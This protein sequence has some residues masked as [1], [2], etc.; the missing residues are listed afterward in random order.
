MQPG[1]GGFSRPQVLNT[2]KPAA[3]YVKHGE[4]TGR[5]RPKVGVQSA[6]VIA[7]VGCVER[8]ES[9]E[10]A[11]VLPRR[12]DH[13]DRERIKLRPELC[14]AELIV[15]TIEPDDCRITNFEQQRLGFYIGLL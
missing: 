11:Q 8:H 13:Y 3:L 15:D 5:R 2:A 12:R 10:S 9:G 4:L 7:L 14:S 6:R 1:K